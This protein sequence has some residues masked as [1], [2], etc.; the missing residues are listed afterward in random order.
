MGLLE[1]QGPDGHSRVRAKVIRTNSRP[2]LHSEIKRHV[3]AGSDVFTDALQS[4]KLLRE[5]YEHQV[6]DHAEKYVDGRVHTNGME[7]FWSLLKRA[8]KGTY[9]A[10]EPFHLF[11]YL[12]EQAFRYNHRGG[13]DADRFDRVSR[14]VVGKRITYKSL[15]GVTRPA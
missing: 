7:N 1:R 12:D 4:Y 6:I 15:I 9:V 14:S 5:D 3:A 11:R 10:V 8:I 2:I 13:V